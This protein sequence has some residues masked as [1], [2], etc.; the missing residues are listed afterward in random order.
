MFSVTRVTTFPPIGV[1]FSVPDLS[2]SK[3]GLDRQHS[4]PAWMPGVW[5]IPTTSATRSLQLWLGGEVDIEMLLKV[6][7]VILLSSQGCES[8]RQ[9]NSTEVNTV[10]EVARGSSSLTLKNLP[11]G[12][13]ITLEVAGMVW[14]THLFISPPETSLPTGCH[15]SGFRQLFV[16]KIPAPD[17]HT[18]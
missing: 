13:N 5:A 9:V 18:D 10:M 3:S 16:P 15:K 17:Y 12:N 7:Q 8:P 2:E 1:S 11:Y 4:C 14:S 6:P